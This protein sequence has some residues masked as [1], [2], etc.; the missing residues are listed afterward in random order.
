MT[1]PTPERPRIFLSYRRKDAAGHAGRLR[2]RLAAQYGQDRVFQDIDSIK[3]GADFA[4]NITNAVGSCHVLLALIG[5]EWLKSK[6]KG[7]RRLDNPNDYVRLEIEAALNRNILVIPI[8][9]DGATM[10]R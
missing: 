10:P 2:D 8:L 5:D 1:E 3:P 9:L 4:K 7:H 6:D